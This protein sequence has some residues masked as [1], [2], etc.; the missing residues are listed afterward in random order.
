M[1]FRS[2]EV[3]ATRESA[4]AYS[5]AISS[6]LNSIADCPKPTIA[7]I[8]GACVGGGCGIALA[9]DLRFASANSRFGVTPA[10]LGLAYPHNDTRRLIDAIGVAHAKDLLYSARLVDAAEAADMGL[11]NKFLD[12]G[13]LENRVLDYIRGMLTRSSQSAITS[14]RMIRLI[15]AGEH[16]ETEETRQLFLDA[17]LSEDFQEGYRAFLEKR[18]P[19][20]ANGDKD[21]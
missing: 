12:A 16:E 21:D 5:L 18:A 19:V 2:E 11:I 6:A 13:E 15:R 20:F 3:Y 14:K 4:E 8:D 10:K 1:L 7:Q 17:F 9:C